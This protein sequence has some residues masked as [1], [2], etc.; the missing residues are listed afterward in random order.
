MRFSTCQP[1]I[2]IPASH[3]LS[4][5]C[6]VRCLL[7][8]A[9]LCSRTFIRQHNWVWSDR[10]RHT[11][12]EISLQPNRGGKKKQREEREPTEWLHAEQRNQLEL[13]SVHSPLPPE[14][15]PGRRSPERGL[16]LLWTGRSAAPGNDWHRPAGRE[17]DVKLCEEKV[18]THTLVA[19]APKV[20]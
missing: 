2:K 11:L 12:P 18:W 5:P 20:M 7:R 15:G 6:L 4:L 9:N 1:L 17:R 8:A 3:I 16:E 10:L 13:T 19:H 14:T